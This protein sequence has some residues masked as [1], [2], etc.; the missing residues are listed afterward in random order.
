MERVR[1]R[2][3]NPQQRPHEYPDA[4]VTILFDDLALACAMVDE[5]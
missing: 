3:R 1:H 2:R 5:F 4:D